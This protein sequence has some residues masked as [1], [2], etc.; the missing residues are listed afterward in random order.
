[1]I[2]YDYPQKG[3]I[4]FLPNEAR[5]EGFP[6]EYILNTLS[7]PFPDTRNNDKCSKFKDYIKKYR[8]TLYPTLQGIY[9]V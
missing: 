8:L 5:M 7:P 4:S 6:P 3:N 1:M 2:V 9:Q